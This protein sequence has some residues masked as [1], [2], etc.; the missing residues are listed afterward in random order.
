[1]DAGTEHRNFHPFLAPFMSTDHALQLAQRHHIGV[2]GRPAGFLAGSAHIGRAAQR[3]LVAGLERQQ[4]H[5]QR[6]GALRLG[7]P[8]QMEGIG[9]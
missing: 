1:M 6:A 7:L 3:Q 5:A 4:Q 9:G 2:V 8:G